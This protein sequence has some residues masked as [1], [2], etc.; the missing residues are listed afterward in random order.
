MR[1]ISALI[2][3][4]ISLPAL[5]WKIDFSNLEANLK[6]RLLRQFPQ[7]ETGDFTPSEVDEIL[8]FI[9]RDGS[10]DYVSAEISGPNTLILKTRVLRRVGSIK[11]LGLSAISSQ[12]ARS[13]F[14]IRE[15]EVYDPSPLIEGGESLRSL[16][17]N[18]GY[19]NTTIDI[20]VPNV[21]QGPMEVLVRVNEGPA[22]RISEIRIDSANKELNQELATALRKFRRRVISEENISAVQ[23]S[24]LQLLR[25]KGFLRAALTGPDLRFNE[26][27]S[28]VVFLL[29]VENPESWTVNFEGNTKILSTTLRDEIL[30]LENWQ[31]SNPNLPQEM[32][33]RI[34][35]AYLKAGHARVEIKFQEAMG[36][37]PFTRKL[38]FNI[39]EGPLVRISD[40]EI[41]GRFSRDPSWY[42]NFL[43]KNSGEL[44]ERMV[45][46]RDEIDQGLEKMI[47][48]LQDEGYV[49]AR[50]VSSRVIYNREKT[51]VT[52][53]VSLDEGPQTLLSEVQFEG[54]SRISSEELLSVSGLEPGKPLRIGRIEM[55]IEKI[56]HHYSSK[57]FLEMEI[58]T[59]RED[60]LSYTEDNRSAS[61]RISLREGPQVRVGSI[62]LSGNDFSRDE[63]I[64]NEIDFSI[65]DILTPE[66]IEESIRRLQRAGHFNTVD[67]TTL[68]A[69]T[70][71][72]SRTVQ[73]RVTERPPGLFNMGVG[74]TNERNLTV[75]G[76]LGI[77]YRNLY[78]TGRGVSA[79]V[80]G[81]YNVA[82]IRFPEH[83]LTLGYL[84]PYL[85]RTRTRGRVNV[86]RSQKVVDYDLRKVTE[87]N[88]TTWSAEYEFSRHLTAIWDVWSLATVKD[89]GLDPKQPV[90]E[91]LLNIASTGPTLDIDFRDNAFNPKRGS[92]LRLSAEYAD[93]NL[94]SS[95]TIHYW[96]ATGTY[97]H[98]LPLTKTATWVWANS[99]RAGYLANL[100]QESDGGVPFD[101]KGFILGGRSTVR[102]Y[103]AGTA[104]VFPNRFDLGTDAFL[105]RT[106]STM[107]LVKSELR[108]PIWGNFGGTVFYDGGFVRISGLDYDSPYRDSAGFGF[109]YE[110]PVGPLNLEWGWKLRARRN[111][112]P[113]R[114]HFS[115]GSY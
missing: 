87:V 50:L 2:L 40:F 36:A 84:E 42:S 85:L 34:K 30:D 44:T 3:L 106:Q 58:L 11:F 75:R 78:G 76:F 62:E 63:L 23:N 47:F 77:S 61:I 64:L 45:F 18:M 27:G 33:D 94:G 100:N 9:Q 80:E 93:P 95:S 90:T 52:I 37:H 114:F 74:A 81:Q 57:G 108:F 79:R 53:Y 101:K 14:R 70:L 7:A 31:S 89:F 96:R 109:R 8:R 113:W 15:N 69:G 55:A 43:R 22:T 65:G 107:G 98:Y 103:E 13:L 12:D 99:M 72:E 86:V 20:D 10:V 83:T 19:Y 46:S 4:L 97:S 66:K 29:G 112:D 110:T 51:K 49:L 71:I 60:L 26:S 38:N 41:S 102:G 67:I 24:A 68:E 28:E 88:Q 5:G 32:A 104:E 91:N 48:A 35:K 17:K 39:S 59:E 111:E 82:D 25:K 21:S 54:N 6:T 115:I 56:K 92:F 16:Y 73:I 1:S 105:L